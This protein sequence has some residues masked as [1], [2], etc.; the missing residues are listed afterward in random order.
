MGGSV[1]TYSRKEQRPLELGNAAVASGPGGPQEIT[2]GLGS[3]ENSQFCG[4][5]KISKQ[6]RGEVASCT[7]THVLRAES[8]AEGGAAVAEEAVSQGPRISK[9]ELGGAQPA[10]LGILG[11]VGSRCWH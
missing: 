1:V 5:N 9:V 6:P 11:E 4:E 7:V 8:L 2:R 3:S 10:R